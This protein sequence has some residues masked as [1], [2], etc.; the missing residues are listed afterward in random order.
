MVNAEFKASNNDD[1]IAVAIEVLGRK[2]M[3]EMPAQLKQLARDMIT[4]R[5]EASPGVWHAVTEGK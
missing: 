5:I 3:D 1:P 2:A 4:S